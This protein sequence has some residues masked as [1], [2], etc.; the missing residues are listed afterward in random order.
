[1]EN[2]ANI[3]SFDPGL[4]TGGFTVIEPTA[5]RFLAA[6]SLGEPSSTPAKTKA[7]AK[8]QLKANE[9]LEKSGD[10][11][12]WGDIEFLAAALRAQRW[13]GRA[14]AA[15]EQAIAEHGPI[16]LIGIESF[17]DFPS[18]A[19]KVIAKRWQTP[20]VIGLLLPALKPFGLSVDEG[21]VVFQNAGIVLSS[22]GQLA[23]EHALLLER[24][25]GR[26]P[27]DRDMCWRG[28]R[29]L[30]NPHLITAGLHAI[31]LSIRT[32]IRRLNTD[33]CKED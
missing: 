2:H 24:L 9:L 7:E 11:K 25:E 1:M 26:H 27:A 16:G 32:D 30:S 23:S 10:D 6:V 18:L 12:V 20:L 5:P 31:A 28:D 3:A 17:V 4:A 19:G 21:T 22:K 8:K 13:V 29:L 33:H 15:V 14:V